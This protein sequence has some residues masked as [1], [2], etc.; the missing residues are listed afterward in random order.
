MG[1][2]PE[3]E[4]TILAL[5]PHSLDTDELLASNRLMAQRIVTLERRAEALSSLLFEFV[6]L[7][8]Y[9]GAV[10]AYK[11]IVRPVATTHEGNHGV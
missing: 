9:A 2:L 7:P 4:H 10:A 5:K 11:A 3:P 8:R 1:Q 6:P